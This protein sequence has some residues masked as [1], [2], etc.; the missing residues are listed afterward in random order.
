MLV[1]SR[2]EATNYNFSGH[3]TFPFRYT[4]LP[5]DAHG[6]ERYPDLFTREDALIHLGVGKNMVASIRYLA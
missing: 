5:K 2:S 1:E 6:L 3:E 4:C